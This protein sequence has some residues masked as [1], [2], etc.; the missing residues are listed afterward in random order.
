[1][2][3]IRTRDLYLYGIRHILLL[4]LSKEP[5]LTKVTQS[6]NNSSSGKNIVNNKR[7]GAVEVTGAKSLHG[8]SNRRLSSLTKGVPAIEIDWSAF[9]DDYL[10]RTCN[11]TNTAKVRLYYAKKYYHVL[12]END[13]HDLL[14]IESEQKR[15]NVMKSLRLLSKYLGCYDNWQEMRRR[16]N[17]KW[18]AGNES[19]HAMQMFFN[20]DLS[21]DVMLQQIRLMA[22]KLPPPTGQI[23]KFGVLVG[24]RPSEVVESVKLINDKE[25]A[26]AKYYDSETMTLSHF[27]FKQFLRTTKK[28]WISFTTREMLEIVDQINDSPSY[29]AIRLA[30]RKRGINC[31]MR[32]CRKI[33]ATH[34]HQSG[35]PVGIIDA[36]QGRTPANIF[37]KHY[38]RPS[39]N[40]RQKVLDALNELQREIES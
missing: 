25:G 2:G 7:L 39:L 5:Y 4:S 27:K 24:L 14:C 19:L 9:K 13:A 32:F 38:Y 28:A 8:V 18:T 23:V 17:L 26:F 35:I 36:L 30:C 11:N 21:L 29:N 20:P 6:N 33:H 3:R 1:L 22:Q 12:L 37:A 40:Y 15:L 34:L 16:Y 10:S 31:D